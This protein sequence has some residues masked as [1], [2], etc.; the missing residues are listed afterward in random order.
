M[1]CAVGEVAPLERGHGLAAARD[2]AEVAGHVR[3]VGGAEVALGEQGEVALEVAPRELRA[4]RLD[5]ARP[6]RLHGVVVAW[7]AREVPTGPVVEVPQERALPLVPD[8]RVRPR[9]G[10]RR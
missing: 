10:R 9:G 1:Q 7:V 4:E 2:E 3:G 8:P 5:R 6:G